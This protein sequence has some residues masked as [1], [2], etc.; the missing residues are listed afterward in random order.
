MI[1]KICLCV[2]TYN[3]PGTI[4]S[5]AEELLEKT[6]FSVLIIDDGSE[7]RVSDLLHGSA[8]SRALASGRLRVLRFE[9][10][11]GKGAALRAAINDCV[12]RGF[13]HLLSID[14]DGQHLTSEVAVLIAE[15][16]RRPWD[17]IIGRRRME[18]D[19]VPGVSKFGRKFSNFWVNYQTGFAIT[20]SQSGFR[21]YPLFHVQGLDFHTSRYDFEIEVLIRLLW[22]GVGVSEVDV[23]VFYPEP[24]FRVSHFN[25]FRDNVRISFLNTILVI[26]SL[27]RSHTSPA[28][29]G[30]ALG[31]GV[32]IGCTPFFGFH[33]FLVGAA[34]FFFRLNAGI[35][36]LGSQISIPLL[37]PFLILSSIWLGSFMLGIVGVV[38]ATVFPPGEASLQHVLSHARGQL[39]PWLVGS[40]TIG[41]ALG[42]ILGG[43]LW[44]MD[45]FSQRVRATGNWNGRSR[46]GK[47]GNGFLRSVLRIFGV[48]AGYF[49]LCFILP[50]FYLFA[51][52]ARRALNEYWTIAS[53]RQGWLSRQIAI[54]K[55][56]YR[57]GQTLMDQ[58]VQKQS[59]G[60]CFKT[61]PHGIENILRTMQSGRGLILLS[62]H[63]GN[64][65]L[66]SDMLKGDGFSGRLTVV[67]YRADHLSEEAE[68]PSHLAQLAA[69]RSAHS[70][71]LIRDALAKGRAVGVMGDRPMSARYELVS[72]MGRLAAFDTTPFRI[73]AAT[74]APLIMTYGFKSRGEFY[75][76]YATREKTYRYGADEDRELQCRRWV[77]QFAD[78]LAER[79]KIY[80]DQWFN[81]FPFWSAA[82]TGVPESKAGIHLEEQLERPPKPGPGS[83]LDEKPSV[84]SLSPP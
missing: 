68:S 83:A 46:G 16:R 28:R 49:C 43:L 40:V 9:N 77:G 82:P 65:N 69:N 78:D 22:K 56:F 3:N 67:Q 11:R 32:F 80:P 57:F 31:A 24:E 33:T 79:I 41:F 25:K 2:P 59:P 53:P 1:L 30:I 4:E 18:A 76:F 7:Q 74:G 54:L 15:A 84:E 29:R 23:E 19:T 8:A 60:R 26:V 10:N 48:R 73:A 42:G 36:F 6:D 66:A 12:A 37:A 71:F 47:F 45:R 39:L 17:L 55:H 75:D 61:R 62:A 34:A 13:T 52:K 58:A 50:Y 81:F 64:W 27:L 14:G 20:D 35:M 5:V 21:L 44:A 51:P 72:F 63:V 38:S 70:I